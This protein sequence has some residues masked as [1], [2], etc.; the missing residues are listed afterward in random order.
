MS[1]FA[2]AAATAGALHATV[3]GETIMVTPMMKPDRN[4]RSVPDTDRAE[5][6]CVGIWDE[7]PTDVFPHARDY[8]DASSHQISAGT[9]VVTIEKAV[10]PYEPK[11]GDVVTRLSSGERG[12]VANASD[13]GVS[14]WTLTL[15]AKKA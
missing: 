11:Q 3:F 1:L 6:T 10:L 5:V 4:G 9:I 8:K 15:S 12:V 14:D 13:E 2:A 7:T